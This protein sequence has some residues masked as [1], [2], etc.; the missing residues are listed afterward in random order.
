MAALTHALPS[1]ESY[2]NFFS[3]QPAPVLRRTVNEFSRLAQNIDEVTR[4]EI[5][6]AVQADPLMTMRLLSH[7]E[8]HRENTQNHDIVTVSS[9]IIMMGIMPFFRAFGDLPTAEEALASRP[10]ALLGLLRAV[11]RACK[12]ARYA[13]NWAVLRRDLDVNEITIAALLFGAAEMMAWIHAPDLIQRVYDIQRA[14]RELRSSAVQREVFGVTEREVQL[15]LIRAWRLP[16]LLVHLLDASQTN[17]PRVR[18][19]TLAVDLARHLVHGWDNQALPDD[20]S[21]IHALLR[22]PPEALLRHLGA[23][24]E[25]WPTLLPAARRSTSE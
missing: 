15:G 17:N 10:Q 4:Q 2:V 24:E 11:S 7:I 19:I 20:I 14:N 16:K 3:R 25:V 9:A 13:R 23:P 8:T 21:K 1:I 18:T 5:A 6:S 12:A 22:I